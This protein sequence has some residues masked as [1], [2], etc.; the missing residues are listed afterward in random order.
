M[1]GSGM[2][3]IEETGAAQFYRDARILPIYEGTNG[4]QA[5]DLVGRKIIKDNGAA[6]DA[7]MRE[8]DAL[9]AE[10]EQSHG[11]DLSMIGESLTAGVEAL[12]GATGSILAAG[13]Q[14]DMD[15]AG[16]VAH[17]YLT[18]AGHVMAGAVLARAALAAREMFRRGDMQTYSP[19]LLQRFIMLA[20]FFADHIL[21]AAPGLGRT[22]RHGAASIVTPSRTA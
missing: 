18:L 20:R 17:P 12:R 10:L 3:F 16:A 11:S 5:M 8:Q 14:G 13:K 7:W 4:I 1:P 9:L 21:P 2:G 19:E 6:M 22:V 15:A